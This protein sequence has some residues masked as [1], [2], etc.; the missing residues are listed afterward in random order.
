MKNMQKLV[1]KLEYLD[2][3]TVESFYRKSCEINHVII[4]GEISDV[5]LL[6]CFA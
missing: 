4:Y 5:Y 2:L 3:I 1:K 6:S